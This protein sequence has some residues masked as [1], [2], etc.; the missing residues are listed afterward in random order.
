MRTFLRTFVACTYGLWTL[1]CSQP[2]RPESARPSAEPAP[3]TSAPLD[4]AAS[5]SDEEIL[6]IAREL[7]TS[8]A[9]DDVRRAQVDTELRKLF[10]HPNYRRVREGAG[11]HAV[12]AYRLGEGGVVVKIVRGEGVLRTRAGADRT[13]ELKATS[14]GAVV[15]GKGSWGIVLISGL[16][17]VEDVAGTYA[18]TVAAATAVETSTG[19]L[20]LRHEAAAPVMFMTGASAGLSADAG[21]TSLTI[22]LTD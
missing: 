17:T 1:G 4:S 19:A 10:Q 9:W 16:R 18:G 22:A 21:K 15:G 7:A 8:L 14:F 5:Y 11:I 20:E 13:F 3:S 6:A 12:G 2:D